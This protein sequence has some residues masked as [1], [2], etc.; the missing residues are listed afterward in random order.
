MANHVWN[1]VEGEGGNSNGDVT[2]VTQVAFVSGSA[3]PLRVPT[4][5]RDGHAALAIIIAIVHTVRLLFICWQP[6]PFLGNQWFCI[7]FTPPCMRW[8]LRSSLPLSP[9]LQQQAFFRICPCPPL[10]PSCTIDLRAGQ[11]PRPRRRQLPLSLQAPPSSLAY[12]ASYCGICCEI[13]VAHGT[14]VISTHGH[15]NKGERDPGPCWLIRMRGTGVW[16]LRLNVSMQSC[17][18]DNRT[19]PND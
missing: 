2:A 9:S 10:A 11:L 4:Y 3:E 12:P 1:K 13:P 19:H 7:N 14:C 18:P 15:T 6:L 17:F 8:C 16:I 5:C